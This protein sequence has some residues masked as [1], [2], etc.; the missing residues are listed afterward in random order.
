MKCHNCGKT[1]RDNSLFC[2]FCGKIPNIISKNDNDKPIQ[3]D[4]SRF[5]YAIPIILIVLGCVNIVL[6]FIKT[7]SL[8]FFTSNYIYDVKYSLLTLYNN[9]S[10]AYIVLHISAMSVRVL[11]VIKR[12]NFKKRL[13][14]IS[15]ASDV[16]SVTC[17]FWKLAT[18]ESVTM[19]ETINKVSA[20]L[21][22]AGWMLA[23][24]CVLSL[25]IHMSLI[26]VNMK[27]K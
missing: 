2:P 22:S 4:T 17:L 26:F 20:S 15:A 19:G 1:I 8:C 5:T 11:A 12:K 21:T 16:F 27:D 23:I 18:V 3:K 14:F 7:I 6:W 9:F 25:G 13:Y 24:V 10:I